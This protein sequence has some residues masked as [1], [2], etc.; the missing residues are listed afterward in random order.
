M[1]K[2]ISTLTFVLIVH[3]T[4][5]IENCQAQWQQTFGPFGSEVTC[6]AVGNGFVFSN[7]GF[8]FENKIQRS[9]NNGM[10]WEE[11]SN[12]M[13][14]GWVTSILVSNGR[15]LA[16]LDEGN[17]TG[18]LFI[19][20]DY[21]E[22]WS[23]V[24]IMNNNKGIAGIAKAGSNLYF[25]TSGN[26]VFKSTNNGLSWVQTATGG[27]IETSNCITSIGN[28]LFLG[29]QNG[30][31][32]KSTDEG[33]NWQWCG[34]PENLTMVRALAVRNNTLF[35]YY[36]GWNNENGAYK[37]TNFGTTWI[38]IAS[39]IAPYFRSIYAD[40]NNV[41]LP[42]DYGV[43]RSSND[44]TNWTQI[45]FEHTWAQTVTVSGG[46]IIVGT[47]AIGIF[48]STN[49]GV[50]WTNTGNQSGVIVQSLASLNNI[51]LCGNNGS[52]GLFISRDN[53]NS[54]TE[55]K[56]LIGSNLS[57]L[58]IR[59]TEIF[60][61][62][63]PWDLL[64]RDSVFKSDDLGITRNQNKHVGGGVFK[65]TDLGITWNQIGLQ[66]KDVTSLAFKNSYLFVG[67]Y[68]EGVFRTSN[69][70]ATWSQV[71]TGL[72]N[73][74]IHSLTVIDS[75]VY[76]GTESGVYASSNNGNLW[77]FIGLQNKTVLSLAV[78]NSRLFAGTRNYGIYILELNGNWVQAGFPSTDINFLKSFDSKLFAGT[79][80]GISISTNFGNTWFTRNEGLPT[81]YL[82]NDIVFNNNFAFTST[83][84]NG[85]WRRPLSEVIGIQNISTEIPSS[86][87]LSQNYPNPFNPA[88]NIKF[89]IAKLSDVKIV[90]YDVMG[91]EVQTLV[92]ESLK[93]GT[94]EVTFDGSQLTSGVYFYRLTSDNF[95]DTKRMLLVK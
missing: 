62:T 30:S 43:Y 32:Y 31:V 94:Y 38:K 77:S 35:A 44:G 20:D 70:G 84:G 22:N 59:G 21:G 71:N 53:G 88:T 52:V 1:K 95:S 74:Y 25:C 18:K 49:S 63:G 8:A 45:F 75:I 39:G 81:V 27:S 78:V 61:G 4:L 50:S 48:T 33:I 72:Q 76:A 2:L 80:T 40:Q 19:S 16:G 54:F 36:A 83:S 24:N 89:N 82:V 90:V 69:D 29:T 65:S 87:S 17:N 34:N 56:Y 11:K 23:Q 6:L 7:C 67:E 42:T 68:D 10:T 57:C 12:G 93:P 58:A 55:Y 41:Y 3:C 14:N 13:W 26:G 51:L 85:I 73:M 15:V 92:N 60:A 47:R 46:N 86:F 28:Y 64:L 5:H 66:N 9:T 91:R 37:T 79:S